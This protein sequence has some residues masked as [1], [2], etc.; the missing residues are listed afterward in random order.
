MLATYLLELVGRTNITYEFVTGTVTGLCVTNAPHP[1]EVTRGHIVTASPLE[2]RL[3]VKPR[4]D[5]ESRHHVEP[6]HHRL[7]L[8]RRK[9]EI[10]VAPT[11]ATV[12]VAR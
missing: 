3:H 10:E 7:P 6:H 9:D 5:V 11:T 2:P 8:H 4:D 1:P 12:A